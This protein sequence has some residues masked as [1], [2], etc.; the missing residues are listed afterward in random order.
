LAI[1]FVVFIAIPGDPIPRSLRFLVGPL[2]A[3]LG[4]GTQ[5]LFL[6]EQLLLIPWVVWY[7]AV[8]KARA[9]LPTLLFV[10]CWFAIGFYN[11]GRF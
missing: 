8:D 7:A 11:A 2:P 6:Y 1:G 5:P 9:L 10:M 4:H 3:L